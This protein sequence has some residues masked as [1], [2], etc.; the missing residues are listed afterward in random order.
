M[1]RPASRE[2]S[3]KRIVI[4]VASALMLTV[5]LSTVFVTHFLSDRVSQQIIEVYNGRQQ[6]VVP[7]IDVALVN[8]D[9]TITTL[10]QGNDMLYNMDKHIKNLS[11]G[12][13][14]AIEDRVKLAQNLAMLSQSISTYAFS[15]VYFPGQD[16]V[17]TQVGS[18]HYEDYITYRYYHYHFTDG[19]KPQVDFSSS[20]ALKQRIENTSKSSFIPGI[21]N[22]YALRVHPVYD[23]RN[24]IAYICVELD[25]E[26]Y[27]RTKGMNIVL[28]GVYAIYQNDDCI[29]SFH[30]TD[31]NQIRLKDCLAQSDGIITVGNTVYCAFVSPSQVSAGCQYINLVEIDL[32]KYQSRVRS[33]TFTINMIIALLSIYVA[34]Q[35]SRAIYKPIERIAESLP[36]DGKDRDSLEWIHRSTQHMLAS[37][38][39]LNQYIAKLE[40]IANEALLREII[41]GIYDSNN[42]AF[43]R[44]LVGH[45]CCVMLL[46]LRQRQGN[47]SECQRSAFQYSLQR[48][49]QLE[50]IYAVKQSECLCGVIYGVD[51]T[52][53]IERLCRQILP[54]LFR[55]VFDNTGLELYAAFGSVEAGA[56]NTAD[57]IQAVR[58]SYEHAADM[59][60]TFYH[61]DPTKTILIWNEGE[62]TS[63]TSPVSL[64]RHQVARIY[65]LLRKGRGD[66]CQSYLKELVTGIE[67]TSS[68]YQIKRYFGELLSVIL[69]VRNE[70]AQSVPGMFEEMDQRENINDAL[71]YL[72]SV[73]KEAA[74]AAMGVE[75]HDSQR[76]F[77]QEVDAYIQEHYQKDIGLSNVAEAFG[78]STSYFSTLYN[79]Y[80]GE[81]FSK[82]LNQYRIEQAIE[83]MRTTDEELSDIAKEVGFNTYKSFSRAFKEQTKLTPSQ[84]RAM[85]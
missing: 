70:G 12:T 19:M 72:Q 4:L 20:N 32:S 14:Q 67:K 45:D 82:K 26:A 10:S 75:E 1:K 21:E 34:F 77:E 38:D 69:Q 73:A 15:F 48:V 79:K 18:G 49:A 60:E 27:F 59:V 57:A 43:S 58:I 50:N 55:D 6:E 76:T 80:I 74:V 5:V 16:F 51:T 24:L 17:I 54:E 56:D 71:A 30:L 52:D 46:R 7:L 23:N 8:I 35:V 33:I 13:E 64:T 37:M 83:R 66:E 85:L 3:F 42:V 36:G 78:Y 40:P 62:D 61:G 53:T 39:S 22:N 63:N 65:D 44:F 11:A 47:D 68:A 2:K 84:Y 31:N 41:E 28:D 25:I 81:S 9:T 29:A